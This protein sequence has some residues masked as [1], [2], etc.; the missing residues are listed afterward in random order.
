MFKKLRNRLLIVN[1]LIIAA[2]VLGSFSV[3]YV[4][5]ARNVTHRIEQKL[6]RAIDDY[7]RPDR[8]PR[9]ADGM[10]PPEGEKP[11]E[12]QENREFSPT[13]TVLCD[14]YGEVQK[15]NMPFSLNEDFYSEKAHDIVYGDKSE[16]HMKTENGYWAYK[17]SA[18]DTGFVIAFTDFQ[19]ERAVML[20]LFLVLLMVGIFALTAAFLIS[21]YFANSS[22][23]P[24]EESY[25]RQ[26]QFVA[27]ASHELKTPLT[28]IN[29]NIDVLLSHPESAIGEE[30]KWLDYIKTESERMTKLT[31]DL[32]Y[33]AKLDHGDNENTILS[34]VSFSDAVENVILLMEAVIFENNVNLVYNITPDLYI[35][36]SS[37]QLKQLVMILIDNAVK[38]TPRDGDIKTDLYRDSQDAVFTIRNTGEGI[39]EEAQKHIFDRFYREDKSRSRESGGY[40]LGLAIA[41][42]ITLTHKG[43]IRVS[44]KKNEYTEFTVKIP[45]CK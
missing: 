9:H 10:R 23:R 18:I 39:S 11:P 30:K 42:A 17:V 1:T 14:A 36:G 22:I 41:R 26:K 35:N 5:T 15:V 40:G 31:N 20:N 16:G 38:Y 2:L 21:L 28:T 7:K 12:R 13:F 34:R 43:S 19:A 3:I 8:M 37:E 27:D 6:D 4:I 29:T 45:V 33:L 24:V 44:S 25:N 32:L